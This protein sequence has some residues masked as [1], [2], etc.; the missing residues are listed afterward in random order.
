MKIKYIVEEDNILVKDYLALKGLSRT[1]RRRARV[2]DVITINGEK[3]KNYFP[4]H[5]GDTL[6]L[7]FVEQPNDEILASDIDLDIKYEDEYFIII[8]KP[9]GISSQP[10]RKH[11]TDNVISAVKNYF[12][13]QG[14]ETNVHLVN[15]LDLNTSGLMIIAKDGVTHFEFSKVKI[16][17]QYLCEI[18]GFIEPEEGVI[19]KPIDRYPAPSILRY[20]SD[21]GKPSQTFYKVLKKYDHTEL[22]E[23]TLGTGRT[24]QIRV[25]FSSLGH[26]L[27]GDELYGTKDEFLKLHCFSLE[28]IH[29]WTHQEINLKEYP[30]WIR[31]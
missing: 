27:V 12:I 29:P 22:V 5:K 30:D 19:D 18:E 17:K 1:L 7:T 15:R 9:R 4:L 16:K 14:I 28:F 23:V 3:A 26:P 8:N 24:H 10:S 13:K 20:V 21:T 11:L 6:E 2:Q 25:H 31:R